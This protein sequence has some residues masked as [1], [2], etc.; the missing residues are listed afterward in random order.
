VGNSGRLGFLIK[1]NRIRK[2]DPNSEK[3]FTV[4][5]TRI[6]NFL[7]CPRCFY[8]QNRIGIKTLKSL[9][10]RLNSATDTLLK[11]TFDVAR[12]KQE[13]HKYF[14]ENNINLI[15]FKHEKMS[16]WQQN[17][18]GVKYHYEKANL[19]VQGAVDDILINLKTKELSP[20]EY[21]STQ[22][23]DGE[24]IKYLGKPHHKSWKNQLEIYGYLLEK[25]GFKIS[26]NSYIVFCNADISPEEW[27]EK[28][29]F[30]V[31]V[32]PYKMD[33]SWVEPTLDEIKELLIQNRIPDFSDADECDMCRYLL[34]HEEIKEAETSKKDKKK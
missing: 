22:T 9:P 10:F 30:D 29:N 1:N 25:N 8:L 24:Q 11:K 3:S 18:Q 33:Y 28:L 26:E 15:P 6:Q 13:V 23:K 14:K 4:S 7:D 21:K 34:E 31:Q 12:D 5:R 16:E 32:I 20:I 27:E 17:F 2:F 19:I